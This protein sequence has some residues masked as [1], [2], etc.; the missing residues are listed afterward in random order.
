MRKAIVPSAFKKICRL[1]HRTGRCF[2][3][4]NITRSIES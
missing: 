3:H 1:H 2:P 4:C